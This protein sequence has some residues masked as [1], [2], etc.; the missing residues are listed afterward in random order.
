MDGK[1]D[2]YDNMDMDMSD[3]SDSEMF[4]CKAEYKAMKAGLTKVI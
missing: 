3:N 1:Q 4:A 2:N